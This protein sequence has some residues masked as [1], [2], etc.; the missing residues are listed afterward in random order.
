MEIEIRWREGAVLMHWIALS[1]IL[2]CDSD[3]R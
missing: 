1:I 2:E 3:G